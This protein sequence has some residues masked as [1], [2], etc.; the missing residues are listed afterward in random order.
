M[1]QSLLKPIILTVFLN[2]LKVIVLY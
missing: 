1:L 2:D